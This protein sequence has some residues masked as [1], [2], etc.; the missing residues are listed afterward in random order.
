MLPPLPLSSPSCFPLFSLQFSSF[1]PSPPVLCERFLVEECVAWGIWGKRPAQS[2]NMYSLL[3]SISLWSLQHVKTISSL[4]FTLPPPPPPLSLPSPS[5]LYEWYVYPCVETESAVCWLQ[6][7]EHL[8]CREWPT[9]CQ[10]KEEQIQGYHSMYIY[11]SSRNQPLLHWNSLSF[12]SLVEYTRV[13]LHVIEGIEGSDY[14]NAN[15]IQ[16]HS[17][18]HPAYFIASILDNDAW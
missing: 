12:P 14:V 3:L 10:Q 18:V 13:S 6:R 15:Y 17:H 9:F 16:V 7:T 5:F 8:S 11:T 1:S 4:E 2:A